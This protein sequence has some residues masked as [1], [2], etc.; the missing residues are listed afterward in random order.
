MAER[1]ERCET[2]KWWK[3]LPGYIPSWR[4]DDNATGS[5]DSD[6]P[7]QG[8]CHRYPPLV[9]RDAD[10]PEWALLTREQF[11]GEWTPI[12]PAKIDTIPSD[13]EALRKDVQQVLAKLTWREREIIK[14]RYGLDNGHR[15]TLEECGRIFKV[16]PERIRT[17]EKKAVAKLAA[18]TEA[19]E[20][21][22][23]CAE[24]AWRHAGK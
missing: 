21:L 9:T 20:T 6:A 8:E 16:T 4:D 10:L 14:L 1:I 15:Y 11:C 7:W 22:K 13:A 3:P 23:Q 24:L 2:C 19:K 17:I 5:D 18:I 12:S